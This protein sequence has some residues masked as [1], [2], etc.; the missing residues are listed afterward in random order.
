MKCFCAVFGFLNYRVVHKR[1]II[2]SSL[3]DNRMHCRIG[4]SGLQVNIYFIHDSFCSLAK[5]AG[6]DSKQP[7]QN[8]RNRP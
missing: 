5:F 3:T 6:Y 4:F 1:H 7:K 2:A 8:T